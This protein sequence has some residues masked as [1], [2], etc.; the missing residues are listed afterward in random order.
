[1]A[2]RR[3]SKMYGQL[4]KLGAESAFEMTYQGQVNIPFEG[5]TVGPM[6]WTNKKKDQVL[7]I[8]EDDDGVEYD[9]LVNDPDEPYSQVAD[10][11]AGYGHSPE[12]LMEATRVSFTKPGSYVSPEGLIRDWVFSEDLYSLSESNI[13]LS[14][15]SRGVGVSL[16][17]DGR[18]VFSAGMI[19]SANK[20]EY[21]PEMMDV[22]MVVAQKIDVSFMAPEKTILEIRIIVNDGSSASWRFMGTGEAIVMSTGWRATVSGYGIS[23]MNQGASLSIW[24]MGMSL[25]YGITETPGQVLVYD[26]AISVLTPRVE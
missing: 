11:M 14:E 22:G 6:G 15:F 2:F 17:G 10:F 13:M 4:I 23:G 19:R 16:D 5:R 1:M 24:S 12:Q 21:I 7:L 9:L 3:A 20:Q 8:F 25:D 26:V 18:L